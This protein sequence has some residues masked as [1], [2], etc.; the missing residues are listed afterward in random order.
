MNKN[1]IVIDNFYADP[2]AVRELALDADLCDKSVLRQN[3]PGHESTYNYFSS[4]L[5]KKFQ[6]ILNKKIVVDEHINAFGRFRF[7]QANDERKTQI[8]FDNKN[9]SAVIYLTDVHEPRGGTIF[10]QHK[11]TSLYG[12][13]QSNDELANYDCT[14]VGEFDRKYILPD[15]LKLDSWHIHLRIPFKYNRLVLFRGSELFHGSESLFG[16]DRQSARLTQN[17]FFNEAM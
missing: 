6:D 10:T 17:F 11:N 15:T 13:P 7:A 16:N 14:S 9:W 4:E 2:H 1:V 5:V 3:F 12:P 8:H